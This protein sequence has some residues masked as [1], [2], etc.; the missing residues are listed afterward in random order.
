MKSRI[1]HTFSLST[2]F[3]AL[4][5]IGGV[6]SAQVIVPAGEELTL[7]L[8]QSA[9]GETGIDGTTGSVH[10]SNGTAGGTAVIVSG[11]L[12]ING[13]TVD[14][15]AGGNGGAGNQANFGSG[16]NGAAG[17]IGVQVI[18]DGSLNL[19]AGTVTTGANG[20]GGVGRF[21]GNGGGFNSGAGIDF[22]GNTLAIDNATVIGSSGGQGANASDGASF[23]QG[24][25]GGAF[26]FI[27]PALQFRSGS[28][29]ISNST[30]IGGNGGD[31]GDGGVVTEDFGSPG[32]FGGDGS[33]ALIQDGGS[34][35]I[36]S[37]SFTGGSG[38]NGGNATGLEAV[39]GDGGSGR[40]AVLQ[41][42]GQLAI[43]GGSFI[44]GDAGNAGIDGLGNPAEYNGYGGTGIL[45]L[46]G[47][48]NI[49]AGTF[50]GSSSGDSPGDALAVQS[51]EDAIN[52]NISG[53]TFTAGTSLAGDG[54]SAL[55]ISRRDFDVDAEISGGIFVGST[56]SA[57]HAPALRVGNSSST[58][59]PANIEISG[60]QFTPASPT[61]GAA[62]I[63]RNVALHLIGTE[64]LLNGQ[65]IDGLI[66]D[67]PFVVTDRGEGVLLEA[68]LFDGNTL[69]LGLD[70]NAAQAA[71][72]GLYFD[73]ASTL[74]I[75]LVQR[76]DIFR[77]NFRQ[78]VALADTAS[79]KRW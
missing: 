5:A 75:T 64:F 18:D 66:E 8:G 44:G 28:A 69:R 59:N 38:G 20:N 49:T 70:D 43:Q 54:R 37:G 22:A 79:P 60:G 1:F 34:I 52:I 65:E 9:I 47:D 3:A 4:C 53:G 30:L 57:G 71:H 55:T 36:L 78:A 12:N 2:V 56:T 40:Q 62:W 74:T 35:A 68:I 39:A 14:G 7:E 42:G 48:L 77:D 27:G 61:G 16:G 10:G 13:G 11:L 19:T 72:E 67:V 24:G 15:G 76:D 33:D 46:G 50:T 51:I 31:G 23:A 21:G 17:G 32:G 29:T 6:T 41:N 26:A 25:D 73:E 45:S 58:S 63:N